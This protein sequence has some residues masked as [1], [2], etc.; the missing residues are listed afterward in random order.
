[1]LLLILSYATWP[2]NKS[3]S[4]ALEDHTLKF[5]LSPLHAGKISF[6]SGIYEQ[7]LL[8]AGITLTQGEHIQFGDMIHQPLYAT[9]V[10]SI[11]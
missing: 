8:C 3:F 11:P 5:Y 7:L 6:S 1:M 10:V 2:G 9:R 4:E